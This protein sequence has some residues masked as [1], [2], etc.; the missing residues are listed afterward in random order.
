[1]NRKKADHNLKEYYSKR[2]KEYDQ[3]YHRNIPDRIQ[4]QKYIGK[5]IN[6]LFKG[7]YVIEL[8]CG[9]GYW[10]KY[11][12]GSATKILATDISQEML[13]IAT[14][15]IRDKSIQFLISDAYSL[16]MSK[17][18][19]T[20]AMSNFWFSHIPK[21]K[22][23]KFLTTLHQGLAKNSL[24]VFVDNVYNKEMGGELTAKKNGNSYKIRKLTNGKT[25]IIL[26]NYYSKEKLK[27]IFSQ[28]SKELDIH[29][30]KYFWL[31]AYK[32]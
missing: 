20:G 22:I 4:E 21:T 30:L 14:A 11:L 5:K 27:D 28:Y 7:K 16:P 2:A 32:I 3:V 31:V 9:T 12:I 29:Y 10:T 24:V 19:F 25:Y 8:A 1:M 26:K 18:L 13:E 15:R 23:K 6:N 17:P